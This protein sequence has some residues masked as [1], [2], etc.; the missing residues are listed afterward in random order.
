MAGCGSDDAVWHPMLRVAELE[1]GRG[2]AVQVGD[3]WIAI[4]RD[5]ERYFALDD[6]CP[7]QG[8]SLAEGLVVGGL[9]ICRWHSWAFD[10]RS[11]QC[12]SAPHVGVRTYD[13]R[14]RGEW[15]EV[16]LPEERIAAEGVPDEG[17]TRS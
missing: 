7:H 8:A 9:V 11:G 4:I 6:A 17:P 2:R 13:V 5:G 10:V 3:R 14:C 16:R 15:L 1:A 12:P